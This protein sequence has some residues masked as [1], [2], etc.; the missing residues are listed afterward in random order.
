VLFEQRSWKP[1]ARVEMTVVATAELTDEDLAE[2][3]RLS[4]RGQA[5]LAGRP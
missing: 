4:P 5:Y 3:D 2:V 1:I